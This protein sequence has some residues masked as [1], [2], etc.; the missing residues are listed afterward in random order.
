MHP[1]IG[2]P[3]VRSS[4]PRHIAFLRAINVGKRQVKMADLREWLTEAG[5]EDV[6]THI[7]TGNVAVTTPSRSSAKVGREIET[8]LGDRC[9]FEVPCIMFTPEELKQVAADSAAIG[10]PPFAEEPNTKRYIVLYQEPPTGDALTQLQSF[11]VID[12]RIWLVG[13]AAHLWLARGVQ[14]ATIF[15]T[16]AKVLAPGTSRNDRVIAALA[17]KWC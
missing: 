11:D 13:R 12:E 1:R 8:L 3:G 6:Q 2:G 16:L 4:M 9:G 14:D 10:A 5:Y 17:A 7:Q 15:K